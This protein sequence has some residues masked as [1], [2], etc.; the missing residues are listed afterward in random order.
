L[1]KTAKEQEEIMNILLVYPEFLVTF[2]SWKHLLK[3]IGK[4]AAF[5]PLG[6]LTVAAMLP[7]SW[8]KKLVDLNIRKLKDEDIRWA[9]YVFVSAMG[10]Q[11]DSAREVISRCKELGKPVVFGGPILEMGC[12]EFES[13]SHFLMGEVENTLPE[14]LEDLVWR[15]AKRI[16][17][18][19][20]FPDIAASPIP[21]WELINPN[22][23]ASMLVQYVRGCPHACTFC[24]V[25]LL[26]GHK[27]RVKSADQFLRELDVIYQKGFRGAVMLAD[28]NFIGSKREVKDMLSELI[29]WQQDRGYPFNFT[30]EADITLAD[31]EELMKQMVL[32]G[33]KKVFLGL[34]TP[35]I[36]SLIECS[37]K[38]NADRDMAACVKT[39][40]NNG[41]IPM[42][43]FIVGFDADNPD[44]FDI[45]MIN[46][47]QETGIVIAMVGVLQAPPKS[48]LHKKLERGGGRLLE[49]SSGNNTDCYPNFVPKMPVETLVRG[50]KRIVE[51]VYSPKKYYERIGIFLREYNTEKRVARKLVAT[52]LKA[53]FA[54][55][56]RI[57]LFGGLKTSYYYW[58]TLKLAMSKKYRRAFPEAVAFQ[59][60]GWHLWTI[61]KSIRKA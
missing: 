18:A 24:N 15:K 45:Q 60:Y 55:I 59:I 32:A 28:D 58:K 35:N 10:T 22:D 3:F 40:M 29:T 13:V 9:D 61:A 23:Y 48:K 6:L 17:P 20:N 12:E 44:T 30:V 53:F 34:E 57:G 43:G 14:F 21:L 47:I 7:K 50:Y 39:I 4:K 56:W 5:P 36:D 54:S 8:Q 31:D 41:L 37:K 38:Q 33:F 11:K 52:E 42:S 26:N 49:V 2:W 27:P 25:A 19:K 16:Y 1:D 46:F 51:T